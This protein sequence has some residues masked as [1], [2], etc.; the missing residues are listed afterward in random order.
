MDLR[1]VGW[2]GIDRI[3]LVEDSDKLWAVCKTLSNLQVS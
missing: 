1:E 2:E 3:P